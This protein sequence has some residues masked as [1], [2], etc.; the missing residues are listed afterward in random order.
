MGGGACAEGEDVCSE[1][2][3]G[4]L[5]V[6]GRFSITGV[7]ACKYQGFNVCRQILA[8]NKTVKKQN[9]DNFFCIG[10]MVL[11]A[12]TRVLVSS[13]HFTLASIEKVL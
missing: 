10:L 2:D 6:H 12:E 1:P 9:R 13:T 3:L 11:S 8:A 7:Q 5:S 4:S